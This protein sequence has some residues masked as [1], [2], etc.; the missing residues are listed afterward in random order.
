MD[1]CLRRQGSSQQP[2]QAPD[3]ANAAVERFRKIIVDEKLPFAVAHFP[4]LRWARIE[5]DGGKQT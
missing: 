4:G 3:A 2:H 1:D 5:M